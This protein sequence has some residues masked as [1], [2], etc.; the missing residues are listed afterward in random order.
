MKSTLEWAAIILAAAVG[1]WMMPLSERAG[2]ALGRAILRR[3]R[4]K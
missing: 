1:V 3:R 4:R 2:D